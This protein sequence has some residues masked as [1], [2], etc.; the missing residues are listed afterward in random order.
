MGE[1][2]FGKH[3]QKII[4]PPLQESVVL[5][6]S[7]KLARLET[8]AR[9]V[10]QQVGHPENGGIQLVLA[11]EGGTDTLSLDSSEIGSHGHDF[12]QHLVEGDVISLERLPSEQVEEGGSFTV[13]A[14]FKV[15]VNP[16]IPHD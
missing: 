9:W 16:G 3:L 12:S 4:V 2:P 10:V 11:P 6:R 14:H 15:V 5:E 7:A 1:F 8:S 13:S